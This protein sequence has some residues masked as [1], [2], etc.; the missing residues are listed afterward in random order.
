MKRRER[1]GDGDRVR[2]RLRT[3]EREEG[4]TRNGHDERHS[5]K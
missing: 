1:N 5:E 3:L 2:E 4:W